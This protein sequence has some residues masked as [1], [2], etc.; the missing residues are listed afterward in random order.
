[1]MH[2]QLQGCPQAKPLRKGGVKIAAAR[3]S[4]FRRLHS[5]PLSLHFPMGISPGVDPV[6]HDR[7]H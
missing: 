6:E 4:V 2:S 5:P 1:M 3:K 7:R